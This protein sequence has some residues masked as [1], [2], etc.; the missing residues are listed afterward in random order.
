VAALSAKSQAGLPLDRLTFVLAAVPRATHR[1]AMDAAHIIEFTVKIKPWLW[2]DDI[3][4]NP[5][6]YCIRVTV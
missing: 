2:N 1:H 6:L 5:I 3:I 4:Y